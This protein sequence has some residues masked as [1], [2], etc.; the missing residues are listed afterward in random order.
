[1][2]E[3]AVALTG[4]T[5]PEKAA[6]ALLN[7]PGAA[8]RWCVV[9]LGARGALLCQAGTSVP[10][11]QPA[12]QVPPSRPPFRSPALPPPPPPLL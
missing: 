6:R 7:R 4:E 1:M 11:H 3:E 9:K 8:T 2:Q 10:I 5:D 12:L